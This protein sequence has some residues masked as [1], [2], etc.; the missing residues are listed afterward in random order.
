MDKTR[1]MTHVFFCLPDKK[2]PPKHEEYKVKLRQM[3]MRVLLKSS[4]E[5]ARLSQHGLSIMSHSRR[6][7]I[8]IISELFRNFDRGNQM[9]WEFFKHSTAICS[10]DKVDEYQNN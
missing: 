8:R 3:T 9:V 7:H 6:S 5:E 2:K 4:L 1:S 10:S